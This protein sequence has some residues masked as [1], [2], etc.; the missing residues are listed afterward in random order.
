MTL[1]C[2]DDTIELIGQCGLDDV[3]PL[4]GMLQSPPRRTVDVTSAA[5][6]HAAIL[7][8][9]LAFS[10]ELRRP[11]GDVFIEKCLAS[12]PRESIL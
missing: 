12:L 1:R 5:H 3:E 8:I 11:A 4:L 6:L 10:P 7:Q 9:L 2:L